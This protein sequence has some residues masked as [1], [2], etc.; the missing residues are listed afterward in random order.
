MPAALSH[1]LLADRLLKKAEVSAAVS[2]RPAFLW[3]AQGP[4]FFYCHRFL[5]WQK[6]NHLRKYGTI[7]HQS[8][9][10][11]LLEGMR[12]YDKESS[13]PAVHALSLIH[14]YFFVT[15]LSLSFLLDRPIFCI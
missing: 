12:A 14:I 3:G 15:N 13:D 10:S 8:A 1:F 2:N 9:P 4:D 11:R 7:F 5:P 6:G